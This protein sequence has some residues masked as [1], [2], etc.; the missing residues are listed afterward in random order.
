VKEFEDATEYLNFKK[1]ELI[2]ERKNS[3][4]KFEELAKELATKEELATKRL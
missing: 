4:L 3:E 1:E 2:E